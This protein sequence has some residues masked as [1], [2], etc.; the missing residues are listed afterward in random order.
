[1]N[2]NLDEDTIRYMFLVLD[3]LEAKNVVVSEI[4]FR[5][6]TASYFIK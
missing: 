2:K 6:G 1:M 5:M 4:D 3:V